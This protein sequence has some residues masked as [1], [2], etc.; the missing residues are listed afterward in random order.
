MPKLIT[1][2]IQ[3]ARTPEG[4]AD[5][6]QVPAALDRFS[7]F[8]ILC[9]Q[10]VASGF[11]ARD[12]SPGGDQ[13]AE[14]TARFP[15][16]T[17]MA[18]VA[19]DTL[20]P[21]GSR[22]RLGSM[23]FSRY[24]V[25]QVLRHSL[26]WPSDPGVMSMPRC[27][28]ELT[29]Q[30]P[31]GLL[32]VLSCHLE[33]FS[34]LQRMAQVAQLRTLQREAVLH[35]LHPRP[36]KGMPAHSRRRRGRSR[37]CSQATSTCCPTRASMPCC[38]RPLPMAHPPCAMPGTWSIPAAPMRPRSGCATAIRAPARPSPSTSLS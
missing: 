3:S 29:L 11:P 10:E 38:W 32:R 24:P 20:A 19:V 15:G 14:L 36:G 18:C 13:F 22:Q 31:R 28:L 4:G 1:W 25:L 6:G 12:G 35:A 23:V 33:Y 21:D 7:D 30:T 34:P 26:P 2:N 37:P 8:D 27:A 5:V 16:Y 9:L 17:P